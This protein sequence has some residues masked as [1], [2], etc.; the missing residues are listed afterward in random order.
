MSLQDAIARAITR[1]TGEIFRPEGLRGVSGGDI[2]SNDF[3]I[4]HVHVSL[5]GLG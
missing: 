4:G 2:G 1:A 5:T 3:F